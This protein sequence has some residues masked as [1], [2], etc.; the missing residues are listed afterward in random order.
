MSGLAYVWIIYLGV[1]ASHEP[2]RGRLHRRT[3]CDLSL[4]QLG[5]RFLAYCLREGEPIPVGLLVPP[6]LPA[7]LIL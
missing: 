1:Q 3:R 5:R 2:W 6:A 7:S 4:F